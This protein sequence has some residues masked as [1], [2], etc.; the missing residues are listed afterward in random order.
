MNE[1]KLSV[2]KLFL[3]ADIGYKR[4]IKLIEA[5]GTAK[6]ALNASKRNLLQIEG[7]GEKT[8][9]EILRIKDSGKAEKEV[10]K[11]A[12]NN[13][14][15]ILFN[16]AE[17]PEVLNDFAD[18]PVALY[19]KGNMTEKDINS[20][21]VVGSRKTTIYGKNV[22]SEFAGY[23]AKKGIT[24]ISGLARG[25]DTE[26]HTAAL[27]NNG[28]T[29]AVLGNGLLFNYPPENANLQEKIP[30]FG[31][32]IS[33]FPLEQ[34]PDLWTFPRRNRII[35]ALSKATLVT[36]AAQK[37]G[38]VITAKFA[39]EYGKDVFAVPGNIYSA[40]SKGT[41]DLIRDGAFPALTP[42]S[43]LEQLA[44]TYNIYSGMETQK[45][46]VSLSQTEQKVLDLIKTFD[47]GLHSDIIA[48]KLNIEIPETSAIIFKLE[49]EGLI[50]AEPGQFYT[51][52]RTTE[53]N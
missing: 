46:E 11:A 6:S 30:G 34:K 49:L 17:Y 7:I 22:T 2:F 33:E 23:F 32:V 50:K 19:L 53:Q 43:I 42:Q 9:D 21:A 26:A 31:A 36:E 29:I 41:N 10:D 40:F 8:A 14:N 27:K 15:I 3:A 16:D 24:I 39:A 48:Q 1:E 51:A 38:A 18:R 4:L 25:V 20:I 44:Y 45:P 28:R 13:I 5:F 37:S 35:A 12:K 52:V 47:D